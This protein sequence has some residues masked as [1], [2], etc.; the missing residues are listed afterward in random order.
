MIGYLDSSA[1]VKLVVEEPETEALGRTL[2]AWPELA[3]SRLARVEVPRALAAKGKPP[4]KRGER[5][6]TPSYSCRSPMSCSTLP[7]RSVRRSFA[8]STRYLPPQRFRSATTLVFSS[9][10]TS[11]CSRPRDPS[12]SRSSLLDNGPDSLSGLGLRGGER[13]VGKV[14]RARVTPHGHLTDLEAAPSGLPIPVPS[15]PSCACSPPSC[16]RSPSSPRRPRRASYGST[17]REGRIGRPGPR[18][19]RC[20]R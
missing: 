8:R 9:P 14:E 18:P 19:L 4:S 6:S 15:G 13:L 17:P 12:A 10:T 1:L 16:W 11:G 2:E 3:T 20:A 7:R 5:S